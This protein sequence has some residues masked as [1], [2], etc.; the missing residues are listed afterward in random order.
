MAKH[1]VQWENKEE[2]P[3]IK[4]RTACLTPS[5]SEWAIQPCQKLTH[6]S[7]DASRVTAAAP[8]QTHVCHL[9]VRQVREED[10]LTAW[11]TA[12]LI[13]WLSERHAWTIREARPVGLYN[14]CLKFCPIHRRTIRNPKEHSS[15]SSSKR[16][17]Y[18]SSCRFF[19]PSFFFFPTPFASQHDFVSAS[20]LCAREMK[21][22]GHR[23]E[24][25]LKSKL[26]FY[27]NYSQGKATRG[28]WRELWARRIIVYCV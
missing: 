10:W 24:I 21:S 13:E 6:V 7:M 25:L 3:N 15:G 26:T 27:L 17:K 2:R 14:A 22:W 16:K 23:F 20:S 18:F 4:S 28:H 5:L 1:N 19:F 8:P 12:W 9:S 11:L